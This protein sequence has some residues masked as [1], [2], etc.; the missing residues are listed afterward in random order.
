MKTYIKYVAIGL[1]IAFSIGFLG[2]WL[3]SAEST[4]A[5]VTG[6]IYLL[7][8]LPYLVIRIAAIDTTERSTIVVGKEDK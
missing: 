2:P 8:A 1:L 4:V 5:V 3:I 6:F 7:I